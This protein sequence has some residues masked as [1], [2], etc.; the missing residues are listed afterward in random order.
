MA[1]PYSKKILVFGA[2]GV[3]GKVLVNSLLNAGN[4]FDRIGVFTSAD[5]TA[6]KAETLNNLEAR[7]AEI[8]IGD[9]YKDT[10][11]LEAYKGNGHKDSS[12]YGAV[13]DTMPGFDTVVSAVGRFAIDKQI[14]LIKLAEK[15]PTIVRFI[16]S[17]YGTDIAYNERSATEKPHQKK[18]K[19]RAALESGDFQ[20]LAYTYIVTG[21][22]SD[23]YMGNMSAEPQMGSFDVA[24]R[25]ATL[26][27]DGDDP[28]SLTSMA[29]VG[30]LLVAILKNPAFCDRRAIR[31]NS[32]TTTPHAILAELERQT[33]SKWKV[34]YTSCGELRRLEDT[35]WAANNPLASIYT[36]RR[37]WTEGST[38]YEET[39]N[40][41]IG[42][43]KMDTL[44]M[45]VQETVKSPVA[46]FQSG[47]L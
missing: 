29:D 17:E 24:G 43:E 36:L 25:E 41:A 8:I 33:E 37:I 18:L 12:E 31:V 38:L 11:V 16:P 45:I 47:K 26:L 34:A 6:S 39:D 13:I 1:S 20:N 7:G 14:D 23:L 5:T 2:T 30:R 46:A 27:G 40:K 4:I 44:E 3:V 9:L 21:P 42:M 19:V 35:A 22:I 15:S 10:D 28:V 32:F